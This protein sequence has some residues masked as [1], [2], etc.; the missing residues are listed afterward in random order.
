MGEQTHEDGCGQDPAGIY[1]KAEGVAAKRLM[2]RSAVRG[3][4][5]RGEHRRT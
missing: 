3:A 4:L 1:N 2:P 5:D